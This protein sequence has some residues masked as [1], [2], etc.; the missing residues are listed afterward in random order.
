MSLVI[1]AA[2]ST[3][4]ALNETDTIASIK[5]NI[6]MILSTPKGEVPLYREFGLDQ[7]FLDKPIPV[8]RV[9]LVAAAKESV[10]KYEP[11][12][13]VIR[14]DSDIDPAIPG[15][16]IPRVEVNIISE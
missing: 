7:S 3:G 12:V 15:R 1:S 2:D 10:E 8:A 11:R 9:L 13:E 5:Q 14:V 4:I 16:L 6:A